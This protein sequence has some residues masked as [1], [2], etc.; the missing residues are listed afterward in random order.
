MSTSDRSFALVVA[1]AALHATACTDLVCGEGTFEQGG[2][3]VSGIDP[4]SQCG[5]GTALDPRSGVCVNTLLDAG[6]GVCGDGTIL[7]FDDAGVPQCVGSGEVNCSV[8]LPCPVNGGAQTVSLCGRVHDVATLAP[9]DDG[10]G[11]DATTVEVRIYDALAY[12]S[13]PDPPPE[14]LAVVVPDACGRFAAL[15]VPRPGTGAIA[16]ATFGRGGGDRWYPSATI[17]APGGGTPATGI[18]GPAVERQ[19]VTEWSTA[20]GFDVAA[21]GAFLPIFVDAGEP[22]LG[23]LPGAPVARVVVTVGGSP[24]P[25]TDFY[26]ADD[27]PATRRTPDI[28][29]TDT[30]VD[31]TALVRQAALASYSGSGPAGCTWPIGFGGQVSGALVVALFVGDCG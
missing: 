2:A 26:F 29:L 1:L 25:E 19:T 3:C 13:Q 15:D 16:V 20:L 23:P 31:G 28:T 30:G 6:V 5:P 7:V 18:L 22:A 14:P 12:A 21:E 4:T 27:D 11:A 17:V 10:S 8:A 24:V 9:L